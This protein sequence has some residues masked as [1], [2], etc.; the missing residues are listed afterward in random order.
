MN[1]HILI[2][3]LLIFIQ[4]CSEE[5]NSISESL[6]S[7]I[8][9][10]SSWY[11]PTT[12]YEEF[13]IQYIPLE[14]NL[15]SLVG[16]IDDLKIY[17]DKFYVL[18]KN[19]A[20]SL[21][22]FDK[23]GRHI[24]TIQSTGRGPKEINVFNDFTIDLE[25]E[26]II[27]SDITL[28]KIIEFDLSGNFIEQ[29][30]NKLWYSYIEHLEGTDY[31]YYLSHYNFSE[32]NFESDK[33]GPLVVLGDLNGNISK[34]LISIPFKPSLYTIVEN[35]HSVSNSSFYFSKV[36]DSKIYEVNKENRSINI[37]YNID[38][39]M[40]NLSDDYL[41]I[42]T[43]NY[44]IYS[45]DNPFSQLKSFALTD[46]YLILTFENPLAMPGQK[47]HISALIDKESMQIIKYF[48]PT[49]LPD[50]NGNMI[51]S[52]K[53]SNENCFFGIFFSDDII[54]ANEQSSGAIKYHHE[55]LSHLRNTDNPVIV[56]VE[57]ND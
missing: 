12:N 29:H 24:N 37:K 39:L 2:Y 56:K 11:S 42:Q 21:F 22:I 47:I 14:T 51:P 17:E 7:K 1:K 16:S 25:R 27:V 55:N 38:F 36:L 50:K 43:N 46:R 31:L 15:N 41:N 5:K 13:S 28:S 32:N 53:Y 40:Q 20:K 8:I 23:T 45:R 18:D 44:R 6:D 52:L 19:I 33:E 48:L 54:S 30:P 34:T 9:V 4:S 57:V 3:L 35:F 10:N 49:N 26:R